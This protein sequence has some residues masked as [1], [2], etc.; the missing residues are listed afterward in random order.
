[1]NFCCFFFFLIHKRSERENEKR[2][3]REREKKKKKGR[4][5]PLAGHQS[6]LIPTV[7]RISDG[8]TLIR[9]ASLAYSKASCFSE[10]CRASSFPASV[11]LCVSCALSVVGCHSLTCGGH[12]VTVLDHLPLSS[13]SE[14]KRHPFVSVLFPFFFCLF[15]NEMV[16]HA[17]HFASFVP[18]LI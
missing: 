8:S 3:G 2:R 16:S 14:I 7:R 18:P 13:T 6:K 10:D 15:F 5:V 17:I 9:H 4:E 12:T 11:R 1:M